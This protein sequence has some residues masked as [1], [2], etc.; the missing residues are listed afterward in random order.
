MTILHL[1]HQPGDLGGVTSNHIS[2]DAAAFDPDLDVN[3][4]RF[5]GEED[6]AI[7]FN[8]G[9]AAPVGDLWLQFRHVSPDTSNQT[10]RIDTPFLSVH[11][12][13]RTRVAGL[14]GRTDGT[15]EA[16]AHGDSQV[17]GASAFTRAQA[18]AYWIDVRVA[19]GADITIAF[20]VD[21]ILQSSATAPNTAGKGKPVQIVF[22]N[23]K[24][25]D[26]YSDVAWYY[27]HIAALDGV[28]TLGRRFARQTPGPAGTHTAWAG[29]PA[30]LADG[31]IVTRMTSETAGQRQTT[32]L[33]GPTGP[34]GAAIAGVHLKAVA[35]AG[36]SGP[37][38]LAGSLRLGGVD[39][40]AAAVALSQESPETVIFSWD[41]DPGTGTAWTDAALPDEIGLLSAP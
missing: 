23:A 15:I 25:H 40:D 16:Q 12:A 10:F 36:T 6:D 37:G 1:G 11:D 38:S 33:T 30:A 24:M 2:T 21:G 8:L 26:H 17:N 3:G 4:L 9:F 35:Q 20:H 34:A 39:H 29:S 27:A 28:S 41:Q 13:S 7:P 32:I 14:F 18:T 5:Y 31:N 22:D 19:V